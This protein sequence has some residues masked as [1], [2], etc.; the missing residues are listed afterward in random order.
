MN[1][2]TTQKQARIRIFLSYTRADEVL[3]KELYQR[4]QAEGFEPWMDTEDLLPGQEFEYHIPKAIRASDFFFVCLTRN[5]VN[6]RGFLQKEILEALDV[7]KEKLRG[8]IYLIP[9]R[10]EDCEVPERLQPFLWA[11]LFDANGFAKLLRALRKQIETQQRESPPA[12]EGQ[13][14]SISTENGSKEWTEPATGMEFVWI[15]PG[16][17]WMGQSEVDKKYLIQ[18]IGEERYKELYLD[19]LPRHAVQIQTGFWLGKHPVTQA[20]WLKVMGKNPSHFNEN[21]VGAEWGQHPVEQVSW[22]ACQAFLRKLNAQASTSPPAPLQR[23]GETPSPSGRAGAGSIFR[24]P[25]EA[26]WEYACR[27]GSEGLFCFGNDI[28]QLQ[29]YAW[30]GEDWNKGSTHPVGVLQPNA[31]GLYDMHGNVWEWCADNW[32]G[33]YEH[34]PEDGGIWENKGEENRRLL[35]GGSWYIHPHVCRC[36]VRY[37]LLPD[38]CDLYYGVRVVVVFGLDS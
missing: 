25:S 21:R 5:S 17:F 33:N 27:A 28:E 3:V 34:A 24:L 1:Q 13:V 12:A 32:H 38:F 8:D 4:L 22:N 35:R 29:D 26:E 2:N 20:Q 37:R 9:V 36:A 16:R 10:L 14:K 31:W 15:P 19:E 23:R 6:R 11:D 7:W 30:Y 18:E